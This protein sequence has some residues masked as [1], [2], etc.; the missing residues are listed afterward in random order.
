LGR[1]GE[2]LP[3][4]EELERQQY[5]CPQFARLGHLVRNPQAVAGPSGQTGGSRPPAAMQA[6]L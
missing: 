4:V 2:A 5:H 6:L 1:H 3:I